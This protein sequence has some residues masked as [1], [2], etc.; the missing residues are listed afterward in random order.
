MIVFPLD[1]TLNNNNKL[2][3]S[4]YTS[5]HSCTNCAG[6]FIFFMHQIWFLLSNKPD[7]DLYTVEA[8]YDYFF[9][10]DKTLIQSCEF[11][12]VIRSDG[13]S[14]F[15]VS[16]YRRCESFAQTSVCLN[17]HT[18]AEELH[19]SVLFIQPDLI[20]STLLPWPQQRE[21]V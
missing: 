13:C 2:M 8:L 21:N 20:S 7:S 16:G 10:S 12:R 9:K 14:V 11:S 15:I 18:V 1:I 17:S 5:A 6:I 4:H 19:S 3:T